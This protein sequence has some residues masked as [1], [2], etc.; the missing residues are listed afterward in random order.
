MVVAGNKI[1]DRRERGIRFSHTGF[2]IFCYIPEV[3]Y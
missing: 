3:K 2:D 1:H